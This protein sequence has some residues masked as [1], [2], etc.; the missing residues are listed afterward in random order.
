MS[1][2][3][4]MREVEALKQ[5]MPQPKKI[6]HTWLI[7]DMENTLKSKDNEPDIHIDDLEI[8]Y[9]RSEHSHII[10]HVVS[11]KKYADRDIEGFRL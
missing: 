1:T 2:K 5:Q 10:I 6:F 4:M 8:K 9:P 11:D 3:S 7:H